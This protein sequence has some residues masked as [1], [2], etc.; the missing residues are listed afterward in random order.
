MN[1]ENQHLALVNR[2]PVNQ[3]APAHYPV[4]KFLLEKMRVIFQ[5]RQTIR[6]AAIQQQRKKILE[7]YKKNVGFVSK[8]KALQKAKT[9]LDEAEK[10]LIQV[11]LD[12]GGHLLDVSQQW[13]GVKNEDTIRWGGN[14][15]PIPESVAKDIGR[16]REL[17]KAVEGE[18]QPFDTFSQLETRMMMSSKVGELM[19]II[20]AVAEEGVF[21][22]NPELLQLRNGSE[23]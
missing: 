9:K 4:K 17:M 5:N 1:D 19:A 22:V 3:E 15:I 11:G 10:E 18:V 7:A 6:S 8:H 16:V 21:K 14:W 13:N 12:E 20:N 23:E 2:I